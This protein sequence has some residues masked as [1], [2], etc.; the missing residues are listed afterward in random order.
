MKEKLDV[1]K[2]KCI[3]QAT[4]NV[5]LLDIDLS[6]YFSYPSLD[7]YVSKDQVTQVSSYWVE[8]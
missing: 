1:I 3:P 5:Q 7:L 8:V 6:I 2:E 4:T